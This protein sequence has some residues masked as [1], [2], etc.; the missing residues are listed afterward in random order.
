MVANLSRD[1]RLRVKN[2]LT[3]DVVTQMSPYTDHPPKYK[4]NRR[5]EPM[6]ALPTLTAAESSR[7]LRDG[8]AGM[9]WNY[10]VGGLQEPKPREI[11]KGGD[12]AAPWVFHD[13]RHIGTDAC[14]DVHN[15]ILMRLCTNHANEAR[16]G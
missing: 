8:K 16:D 7:R 3:P 6:R 5:G 4:C 10:G 12:T 2:L 11:M 14:M 15:M 9:V 13:G 1:D